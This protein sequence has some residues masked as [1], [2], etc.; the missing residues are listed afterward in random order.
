VPAGAPVSVPAVWGHAPAAPGAAE[1]VSSTVALPTQGTWCLGGSAPHR[2]SPG[3]LS[4]VPDRGLAWPHVAPLGSAAPHPGQGSDSLSG[5]AGHLAD[6]VTSDGQCLTSPNPGD[7]PKKYFYI[8]FFFLNQLLI[9]NVIL[10]GLGCVLGSPL[11][12]S[13]LWLG[14][15]SLCLGTWSAGSGLPHIADEEMKHPELRVT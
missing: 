1:G 6:Q 7:P 12:S 14:L 4:T 15:A 8:F 3:G 9:K 11:G 2:H 10:V 5:P 13:Q